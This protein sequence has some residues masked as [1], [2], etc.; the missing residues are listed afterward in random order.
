M[1]YEVKQTKKNLHKYFHPSSSNQLT[2]FPLQC[3]ESKKF[4][5]KIKELKKKQGFVTILVTVL[6]N[7]C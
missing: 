4:N 2:Y 3:R 7:A 1:Y 6:L 5:N